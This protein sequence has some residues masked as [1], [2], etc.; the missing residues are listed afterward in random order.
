LITTYFGP[1]GLNLSGDFHVMSGQPWAPEVSAYYIPAQFR[2]YRS[3]GGNS[4]IL[5]EQRGSHSAPLSAIMN[6]RVGKVFR[7]RGT[8]LELQFDIFNA[9]NGK[10][11]YRTI[12]NP[13]AVYTDGTSAYGQ[14][15]S[16]FPPRNSR[17]N[18]TWRF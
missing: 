17:L 12:T 5:L 15:S 4:T 10:Y 14:P 9:L 13:W 8:D 2:P 11:Y 16:L 7:I 1:W 3:I 6:L 18:I